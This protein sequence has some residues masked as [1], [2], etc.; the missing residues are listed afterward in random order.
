[1]IF[2]STHVKTLVNIYSN[3]CILKGNT[4]QKNFRSFLIR[5]L[6][7]TST[8]SETISLENQLKGVFKFKNSNIC[9][10]I[11]EVSNINYCLIF[12][13]CYLIFNG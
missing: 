9:N 1:M 3:K 6:H 2:K 8:S 5:S 7:D 10:W 12:R 13:K 4:T 11:V